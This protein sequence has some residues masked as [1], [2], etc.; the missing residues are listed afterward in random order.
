MR[1]ILEL[2]QVKK[3]VAPNFYN[4]REIFQSV[5][6][7]VNESTT[8][9]QEI[10]PAASIDRFSSIIQVKPLEEKSST[11]RAIHTCVVAQAEKGSAFTKMKLRPSQLS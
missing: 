11:E 5:S 10:S 9:A 2:N 8:H 4:A 6:L 1:N 3:K 7:Q